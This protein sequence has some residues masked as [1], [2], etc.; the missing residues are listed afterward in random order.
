LAFQGTVHN[1]L[2]PESVLC[3]KELVGPSLLAQGRAV[4][5]IM[6]WWFVKASLW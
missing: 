3:P 4:L 6:V 1:L 5:V 2:I